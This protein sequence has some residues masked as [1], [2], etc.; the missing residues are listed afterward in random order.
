MGVTAA[1]FLASILLKEMRYLVY[2]RYLWNITVN[3]VLVISFGYFSKPSQFTGQYRMVTIHNTLYYIYPK[4]IILYILLRLLYRGMLYHT[5]LFYRCNYEKPTPIQAQAMPC[6]MSG[7]DMI[8]EIQLKKV[9]SCNCQVRKIVEGCCRWKR[10][11]I[12]IH[13][14]DLTPFQSGI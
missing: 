14:L 13:L 1:I 9:M 8:G 3:I 2:I 12:Y 5:L 4:C 11:D 6:V 10:V 7:R